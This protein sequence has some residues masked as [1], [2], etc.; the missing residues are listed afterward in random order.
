[1]C[2]IVLVGHPDEFYYTSQGEAPTV[3][4]IDDRAN[5]V[6]TKEA[7]KLLGKSFFKGNVLLCNSVIVFVYRME[8]LAFD[9]SISQ[10]MVK[11]LL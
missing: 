6:E 11:P 7:F 8:L 3:D 4:G 1:M 10:F 5:L 9:L 2:F